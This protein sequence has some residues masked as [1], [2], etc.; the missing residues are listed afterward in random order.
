[1]QAVEMKLNVI[2]AKNFN[3]IYSLNRFQ[4]HSLIRKISQIPFNI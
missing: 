2:I 4:N 1:M 3:L